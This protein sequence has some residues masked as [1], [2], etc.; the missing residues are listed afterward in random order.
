MKDNYD[1]GA[2]VRIFQPGDK[3][4]VRLVKLNIE[5]GAKLKSKWS[6]LRTVVR[7][8]GLKVYMEDP[9]TRTVQSL[10]LDSVGKSGILEEPDDSDPDPDYDPD[11]TVDK[12]ENVQSPIDDEIATTAGR[13]ATS[14]TTT[15]T[16]SA[17]SKAS[18]PSRTVPR[19]PSRIRKQKVD[20]QME[21]ESP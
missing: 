7:V 13:K 2:A 12:S 6:S 21:Y 16:S 11:A 14:T 10:H 18:A 20:P 1:V 8:K 15:S 4:R 19:Y 17:A 9:V 3:V 5:P